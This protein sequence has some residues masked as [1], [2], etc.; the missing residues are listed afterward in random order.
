ME[1]INK[2]CEIPLNISHIPS[3]YSRNFCST[4]GGTEVFWGG[5]GF[6]IFLK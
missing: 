3:K 5:G 1:E 4:V 2:N 6:D